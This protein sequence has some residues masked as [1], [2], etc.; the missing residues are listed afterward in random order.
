VNITMRPFL[1]GR[2]LTEDSGYV[3]KVLKHLCFRPLRRGADHGGRPARL[4]RRR[5][6]HRRRDRLDR[7]QHPHR[8]VC[9]SSTK[10]VATVPSTR[11]NKS[12]PHVEYTG[13]FPSL[14]SRPLERRLSRDASGD[15]D[16]SNGR[17]QMPRYEAS[18]FR[19]ARCRQAGASGMLEW[20][21]GD[22]LHCQHSTCR[23]ISYL[24]PTAA[25]DCCLRRGRCPC[26]SPPTRAR[27]S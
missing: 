7:R 21:R 6:A 13:S 2:D 18:A 25:A 16:A 24:A 12:M 26:N 22:A 1:Y 20:G 8:P 23:S 17:H 5:G 11:A 15:R 10:I 14:F 4:P 9:A 27:I 19:A 3:T